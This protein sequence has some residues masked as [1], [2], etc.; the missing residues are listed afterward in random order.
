MKSDFSRGFGW[1]LPLLKMWNRFLMFGCLLAGGFVWSP[2]SAEPC[3]NE[4]NAWI[5]TAT[6][7]KRAEAQSYSDEYRYYLGTQSFNYRPDIYGPLGPPR[8]LGK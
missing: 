2:A 5:Q 1:A 4:W 3:P 6:P 7:A 8:D